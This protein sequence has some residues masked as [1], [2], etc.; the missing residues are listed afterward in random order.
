MRTDLHV[1][2]YTGNLNVSIAWVQH[3]QH[4]QKETPDPFP[5]S[6]SYERVPSS[7][8]SFTWNK[9]L[10]FLSLPHQP[11]NSKDYISWISFLNLSHSSLC[12]PP[13]NLLIISEIFSHLS[14]LFL[15]WAQSSP[16]HLISCQWVPLIFPLLWASQFLIPQLS[17]VPF[18]TQLEAN[19][20]M[21]MLR[22]CLTTVP[23]SRP[24][25]PFWY[26]SSFLSNYY[27]SSSCSSIPQLLPSLIIQHFLMPHLLP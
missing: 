10:Y 4:I 15:S 2:L 16:L 18:S 6:L 7:T 1:P 25:T 22:L 11:L 21:I 24:P 12:P 20:N 8:H 17:W 5:H 23:A 27:W 19:S 9:L 13:D 3:I 14:P 26:Q